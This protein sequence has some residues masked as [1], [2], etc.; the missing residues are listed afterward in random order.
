MGENACAIPKAAVGSRNFADCIGIDVV[1]AHR[2]HDVFHLRAI[3]TGVHEHCTA[4]RTGNAIGK[5]QSGI[6]PAAE[7]ECQSRKRHAA[8][9]IHLDPVVCVRDRDGFDAGG[10]DWHEIQRSIGQKDIGQV[11]EHEKA[12]MLFR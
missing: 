3:R 9:G 1:K 7:F 12:F 11:T 10:D 5:R 6:V 2:T 8:R 4:D